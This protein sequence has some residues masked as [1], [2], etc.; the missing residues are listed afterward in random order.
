M[1]K[2]R[3]SLNWSRKILAREKE[4]KLKNLRTKNIPNKRIFIW[5]RI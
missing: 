4:D 3:L 1:H 5:T 2:L